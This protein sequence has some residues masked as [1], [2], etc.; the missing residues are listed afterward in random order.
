MTNGGLKNILDDIRNLEVTSQI[1]KQEWA[2][3]VANTEIYYVNTKYQFSTCLIEEK[4]LGETP[5]S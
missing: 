5:V 2:K 1:F 3:N 4:E